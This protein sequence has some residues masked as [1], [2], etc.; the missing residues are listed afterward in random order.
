MCMM[1]SNG[2]VPYIFHNDISID[3]EYFNEETSIW[4]EI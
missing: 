3:S 2:S 4:T 1:L